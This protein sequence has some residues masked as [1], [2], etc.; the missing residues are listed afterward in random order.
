MLSALALVLPVA[1]LFKLLITK[2]CQCM[3]A[4]RHGCTNT[5]LQPWP[6]PTWCMYIHMD[7]HNLA[8]EVL[9][10]LQTIVAISKC[11]I[12]NFKNTIFIWRVFSVKSWVQ[13]RFTWLNKNLHLMHYM[14]R[15]MLV[16][17]VLTTKFKTPLKLWK[18]NTF[19]FENKQILQVV[20]I[21]EN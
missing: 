21:R 13:D 5:M 2:L 1:L 4:Q 6:W 10:M 8:N 7:Y 14:D 3:L 15:L 18:K 12:Y 19:Y 16:W 11:M 20:Q 9:R 17:M